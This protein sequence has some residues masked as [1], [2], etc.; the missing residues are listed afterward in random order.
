MEKTGIWNVE[1]S[2]ANDGLG[3]HKSQQVKKEKATAIKALRDNRTEIVKGQNKD[4]P[5][6]SWNYAGK[7]ET[8]KKK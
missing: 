5:E 6:D 7:Q 8:K 2:R 1:K 4:R 3:N